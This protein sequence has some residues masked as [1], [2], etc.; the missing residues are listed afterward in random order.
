MA[1]KSEDSTGLGPR[2]SPR[3][4]LGAA[5]ISFTGS[6]KPARRAALARAQGKNG[7]AGAGNMEP[8]AETRV[9]VCSRWSVLLFALASFVF[10]VTWF[11]A[12]TDVVNWYVA[13]FAAIV[14]ALAA[15]SFIRFA[16]AE[17]RLMRDSNVRLR[18]TLPT[19]RWFEMQERIAKVG[20]CAFVSFWLGA[21]CYMETSF[22]VGFTLV[23]FVAFWMYMCYPPLSHATLRQRGVFIVNDGTTVR[24]VPP[25]PLSEF[26]AQ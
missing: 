12:H 10:C 26:T 11:L 13:E 3:L 8:S 9:D 25:P 20:L 2:R 7:I 21:W 17:E 14:L 16:P 1:T 22:F 6:D 5:S 4:T 23:A 18:D 15:L 19:R 24:I